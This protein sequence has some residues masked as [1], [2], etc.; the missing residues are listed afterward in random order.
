M[1]P[2]ETG[3]CLPAAD[4]LP[5]GDPRTS[6]P[7]PQLPTFSMVLLEIST[8]AGGASGPLVTSPWHLQH[9][10]TAIVDFH[11][12]GCNHILILGKRE[13][14][15]VRGCPLHLTQSLSQAH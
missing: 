10:V 8:P 12:I 6:Q 14:C 7:P 9:L 4:L 11:V 1:G 15:T 5:A 3:S 2:Q 13:D